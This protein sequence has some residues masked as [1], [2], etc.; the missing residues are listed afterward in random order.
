MKYN[1][2]LKENEKFL[3]TLDLGEFVREGRLVRDIMD[4][5]EEKYKDAELPECLEGCIFNMMD[6]YDVTVYLSKRYGISYCE[7]NI[8]VYSLGKNI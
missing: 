8:T 1:E 5:I 4:E 6:E 7:R 2:M 3:D